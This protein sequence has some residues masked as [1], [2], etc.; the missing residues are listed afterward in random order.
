MMRGIWTFFVFVTLALF[1]LKALGQSNLAEF[2]VEYSSTYQL[3]KK[4]HDYL[5]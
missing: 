5:R 2:E 1:P 4:L 3:Q